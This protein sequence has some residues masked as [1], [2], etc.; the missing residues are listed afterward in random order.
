MFLYALQH[1]AKHCGQTALNTEQ[2]TIFWK[3]SFQVPLI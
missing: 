1:F 2:F 3:E